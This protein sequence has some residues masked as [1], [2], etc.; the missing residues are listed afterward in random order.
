MPDDIFDNLLPIHGAPIDPVAMARRDLQRAVPARFYATASVE[1]CD[2]LFALALDGKPAHTPAR[3][4]LAV[5]TLAAAEA[6]A[7][8]WN[9]QGARLAPAA[10]P[11]TRL[12]NSA[13]DGVA[14]RAA[15]TRAEILTYAGS[16]LV[17]YRAGDPQ[18]LVEAQSAAWD[19]ILAFARDAF[20]ARFVCS[21]G[22]VFT[23]QPETTLAA[24]ALGLDQLIGADASTPFRLAALDV[25][26]NL[27]GSALIAAAVARG[28]LAP[29]EAWAAAHVDEDHQMRL[30]GHDADA[31]A[32]RNARW[33]DMAAAARFWALLG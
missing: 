9:A 17:C 18:A 33:I 31:L 2:S 27:A 24:F 5:P 29:A 1:P 3:R 4:R 28:A 16:D 25:M 10:M 21:E 15:E 32:R 6:L 19:P 23:A 22:V 13:I 14:A 12:A 20:G 11:L 26:T 8:E 30:W 7:S